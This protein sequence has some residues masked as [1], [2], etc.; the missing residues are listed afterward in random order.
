MRKLAQLI[1]LQDYISRYELDLYH[2]SSEYPKLK[3]KFWNATYERWNEDS[4]EEQIDDDI[5][6]EEPSK[7]QSFKKA[8]NVKNYFKKSNQLEEHH[9]A[10]VEQ[11]YDD[12]IT[13]ISKKRLNALNSEDDLKQLFLDEILPIQIRWASSTALEQSPL[14]RKYQYESALKFFIQRFPDNYLCMYKPVFIIRNAP[15]E[16]DT[17]LISPVAIHCV[18][19]IEGRDNSVMV[20]SN[21][22]FWTE[23][24]MDEQSK[25]LNPLISLDRTYNIVKALLNKNNNEF[26]IKKLL[27]TKKQYVDFSTIPYDLQVIDKKSYSDW[28][29]SMR[30]LSSPV[31]HSQL[32]AA[33]ILLSSCHTIAKNRVEVIGNNIVDVEHAFDDKEN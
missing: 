32:K 14:K 19:I 33:Q 27:L 30:K 3:K 4:E 25:I 6:F 9:E 17:I 16:L 5:L 1:K 11:S 15:I 13:I 10:K 22:K 20:A 7:L 21:E 26:P 2:Y 8:L 23:K 31:K 12:S 29:N 18:K 28:F 24:Y